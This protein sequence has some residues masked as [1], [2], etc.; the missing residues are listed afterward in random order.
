MS[1]PKRVSPLLDG[2]IMGE[3][4]NEHHGIFCCP[5]IKEDTDEKYIV[6]I[7]SVPASPAQMDAL[8]LSGAYPDEESAL[9]YYK[10]VANEII[11]E[12]D[13][14]KRL[15]EQE[16]YTPYDA[17]QLEPK[18]DGKG[19]DIYLLRTY[20]RTLETHFKRHVFTHLDALNLGL[21]LCAAMSVSRRSGYLYVG[22][23]P[24]NI[25]VTDQLQYKVGGL[26]FVKLDS[27]KYMSLPEK[28][29]SIYTPAEINDAYA[30]LNTTIDT[31][32]IGLILYQAYNNGE[33]P[34]NDDISPGDKLPAPL[35]ADYEMTE[36]IL[37][38]C[39]PDPAERW[40]EPVQMG[41]AIVEYMQRNGALDTP[42]VPAPAAAELDTEEDNSDQ[43]EGDAVSIDEPA[44]ENTGTETEES[45]SGENA[46]T[47]KNEEDS[48]VD[49]KLVAVPSLSDITIEDLDLTDEEAVYEELTGEVTEILNQADEL[50]TLSVP[51]PVSVPDYIE[52]P[53]LEPIEIE[54]ESNEE[55]EV[56]DDSVENAE[57]SAEEDGESMEDE[58]EDD[59]SSDEEVKKRH[60]FRNTIIA[61]I[62]A[63]LLAVGYFLYKQFFVIVVDSVTLDGTKDALVVNIKTE[64]N[65]S[66]LQV[67]CVDTYGNQIPAS[68]IDG[69]A[70]FK[71]LPPNTAYNIK[72]VAN[73]YRKVTGVGA[74]TYSTPVQTNI[75]HFDAI[76]G[77]TDGSVI[78]NFTIDG[79]DSDEWSVY[80]S[81]NGEEERSAEVLAHRATISD[82]TIGKEYN[83]RLVPKDELYITGQSEILYTAR[84]VIKA[85]NMAIVSCLNNELV[86]QWATP[87]GEKVNA[88]QVSCSGGSYNQTATVTEN[89]VTFKNLDH[90]S[91]FVV[92]VKAEN[93]SE[94][95][96]KDIPA[97]SVTVTD[98]K[99]D[100]GKSNT[101][102]VTWNTSQP[103][104]S[105][106]WKLH[107]AVV[108][109]EQKKTIEC[110]K[111]EAVI[112]SVIP[113]VAYR[114][115]LTDSKDVPLLSPYFEVKTGEPTDYS[116]KVG[117]NVLKRE[118]LKFN[119]CKTASLEKWD[120]KKISDIKLESTFAVGESGSFVIELKKNYLT[121]TG[122]SVEILFI[123]RNTDSTPVLLSTTTTTLATMWKNDYCKLQMPPLPTTAGTYTIDVYFN[124]GLAATQQFKIA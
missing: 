32:A 68:V 62:V 55:A 80:Y 56:Q 115:W 51:E 76:T 22:L 36:I 29:R 90:T 97:N 74:L 41:Q 119:M 91:N 109:V 114:I 49:D 11:A 59:E 9:A 94:G 50:A 53:E 117:S 5:A 89:T 99:A 23:K 48:L 116:Q 16:G 121:F 98:M 104:P 124:G 122:D 60:W 84:K 28:S 72:V 73:G 43:A 77:A 13:I 3:P 79:P 35:Y 57:T 105:E 123:V 67:I 4:I 113:N 81:T 61:L 83:F 17:W 31:Y 38:A 86:V 46:V 2:L 63:S 108:G 66:V 106:G 33:L 26:G 70:T 15:S 88:W 47:E 24:G 120:G 93:M 7:I 6:K 8:L 71:E 25:F 111:N 107:Y 14:Q 102:K 75:V 54:T 20:N 96:K 52:L 19:Y 30:A 37:K 58:D 112:S 18:E 110:D 103:I 92:E 34:F 78:L 101:L 42:I 65:A 118:D 100:I 69:K 64:D 39:D 85:E 45:P 21:D 27:L 82:L 1:E 95:V 12:I 40:Q 87:A 44:C 10:D